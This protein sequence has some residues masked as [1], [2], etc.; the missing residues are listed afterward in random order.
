MGALKSRGERAKAV[1]TIKGEGD[2][3]KREKKKI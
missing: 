1:R 3:G 2:N